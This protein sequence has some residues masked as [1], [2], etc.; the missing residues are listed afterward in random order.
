MWHAGHITLL[1]NCLGHY[2]T[3]SIPGQMPFLRRWTSSVMWFLFML[4]F[5]TICFSTKRR[6]ILMAS[7]ISHPL[8][9]SHCLVI[10]LTIL[11]RWSSMIL[12]SWYNKVGEMVRSLC[13]I[14]FFDSNVALISDDQAIIQ[15]FLSH[16][17]LFELAGDRNMW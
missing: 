5:S 6:A 10:I 2:G 1:R 3:S 4:F 13:K 15:I 14:Y 9:K 7:V 16:F 11:R 12:S 17:D 8:I